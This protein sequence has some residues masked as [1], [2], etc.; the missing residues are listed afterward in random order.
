MVPM[1]RFISFTKKHKII[2]VLVLVVIVS[3]AWLAWGN[4]SPK[5][6][7]DKM[8]YLGK[9]DYGNIL[10]FDTHPYSVYYYGTDMSEEELVGYFDANLKHPVDNKAGYAD[11][12]FTK[13][14][15]DFYMTYEASSNFKTSKKYTI[16]MTDEYY[17]IA[18]K[19]L[20]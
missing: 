20:K 11:V 10:G 4:F 12:Y 19:H 17:N 6:L 1:N 5:P 9:E 7:G 8:E 16:S 15:E 2:T 3:T 13:S 18:K 14:G